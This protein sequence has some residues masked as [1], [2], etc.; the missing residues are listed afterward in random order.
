MKKIYFLY[1]LLLFLLCSCTLVKNPSPV[2]Y[3]QPYIYPQAVPVAP[4]AQYRIQPGDTLDIKFFYNPQLNEVSL[5]VRP[6]GRISLQLVPEMVVAGL[7]P[8]EAKQLLVEKYE[9]TELRNVE[10][11]VQVKTFGGQRI[12]VDGEVYRANLYPL[13]GQMTTLQAIALAGG[14]KETARINEVILIRRGAD[15]KPIVTT[16]NLERARNGADITQDA[17][18]MP[19]DIVFVPRSPIADVDLWVDQYIRRLLPFSLPS[20]IPQPTTTSSW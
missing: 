12:Y 11:S 13:V 9:A 10:V 19:Y 17:L 5:P 7:T 4:E 6:D 1:P 14:L 16:L 20:P 18:L 3:P 2:F 8:Q 15:N